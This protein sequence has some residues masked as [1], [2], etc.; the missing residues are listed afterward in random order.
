MIKLLMILLVA[1]GL[2]VAGMATFQ[3]SLLYFPHKDLQAP[4]FYG[5]A[6]VDAGKIT[7]KDGEQLDYWHLPAAS[8]MPTMLYFHGNGGH[9]GFRAE[10]FQKAVA[11]GYGVWMLSYR[12]YGTSTGSPSEK[13]FYLD[14]Q[15]AYAHLRQELG[16][17]DEQII[18]Y[19]ESLGTG[20]AIHLAQDKSFRAL[21]LQAPFTSVTERA[22]EIYPW[23]P[24]S[25]VLKDRF[26]SISRVG[27]IQTPTL[28][29][30]AED[31][32]IVPAYHAKR[33]F[34]AMGEPKQFVMF[35]GVSHNDFPLP[36]IF[37]HLRDF[38]NRQR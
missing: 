8:N 38:D 15:A 6:G 11:S 14:A 24:V 1:Y 37:Q 16:L 32:R 12:G 33:L 22:S 28:I 9:L 30:A 23:L 36:A 25:L 17:T 7:T 26:N 5:L 27:H 21:V 19:G 35:S 34:D 29:L 18:I 10:F 20:P 2:V 4:N 31:D 13:G 3:R